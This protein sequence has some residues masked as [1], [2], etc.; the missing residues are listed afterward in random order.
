MGVSDSSFEN[1]PLSRR[2]LLW[3]VV[4]AVVIATVLLVTVVLPT[5]YQIDPTGI[6][7]ALGLTAMKEPARTLQIQEVV[8]GNA[9]YREA[10]L[11]DPGEPY[12]LP[13]PAVVQLKPAAAR[14]DEITVTLQPNEKTEIKAVLDVAQ[15]VLYSWS[16]DGEIYTDFHGHEPSTGDDDAFVRYEEQQT[17]HAGAGSLVAPFAG[18]HGW[19]WLNISQQPVKITLQMQGYYNDVHDYG[20]F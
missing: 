6:G 10:K 1:K 15:V 5:E 4:A 2:R 8:G 19:F 12:P 18:E 20:L 13:N 9:T 7:G 14:S 3:S 11:P 16:A 17:G